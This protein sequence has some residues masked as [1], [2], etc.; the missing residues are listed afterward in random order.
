MM[1]NKKMDDMMDM[2]GAAVEELNLSLAK[3]EQ[4]M[5]VMMMSVIDNLDVTTSTCR[6]DNIGYIGG[7]VEDESGLVEW[8]DGTLFEGLHFED[9]VEKRWKP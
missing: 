8:E 3:E 7:E 5:D 6:C 1:D 9:W 2:T 4:W